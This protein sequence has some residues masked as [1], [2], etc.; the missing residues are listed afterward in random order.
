MNMK[1]KKKKWS[2]QEGQNYPF[3]TSVCLQKPEQVHMQN[4]ELTALLPVKL[5]YGY[6]V[7]HHS[8]LFVNRLGLHCITLLVLICMNSVTYD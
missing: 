2:S 4:V 7:L 3:T 1:T 5:P 6:K 8:H